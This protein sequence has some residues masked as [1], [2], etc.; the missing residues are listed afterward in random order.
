MVILG[1]PVWAQNMASPMRTYIRRERSRIK[2]LAVF[3]T[4]IDSGG[5]AVMRQMETLVGRASI[6]DLVIA[7]RDLKS[8]KLDAAINRFAE[9]IRTGADARQPDAA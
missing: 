9:R 2:K 6:A 5:E 4:E 1:C 3:C 7:D 8:G